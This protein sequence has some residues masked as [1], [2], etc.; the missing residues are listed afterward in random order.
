VHDFLAA[1]RTDPMYASPAPAELDFQH[2]RHIGTYALS[3]LPSP[4]LAPAD[5]ES[6]PSASSRDDDVDDWRTNSDDDGGGAS[7][8]DDDDDGGVSG[9][10]DDSLGDRTPRPRRLSRNSSDDDRLS[11]LIRAISAGPR[12]L[13]RQQNASDRREPSRL[14]LFD[15]LLRRDEMRP[16]TASFRVVPT[17]QPTAHMC[18]SCHRPVRPPDDE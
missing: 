12:W 13:V 1:M 6:L 11:A 17:S 4:L 8:N 15:Q 7:N 5:A 18:A 14:Q 10:D 9:D 3:H 16:L 2:D